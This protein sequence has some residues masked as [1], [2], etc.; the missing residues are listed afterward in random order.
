MGA[1]SLRMQRLPPFKIEG[2]PPPEYRIVVTGEPVTV[3]P[4]RIAH[5]F[6]A[7]QAKRIDA[8]QGL[9]LLLLPGPR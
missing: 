8:R 3:S 5:I 1:S 7:I 4:E 2:E 9:M 6:E